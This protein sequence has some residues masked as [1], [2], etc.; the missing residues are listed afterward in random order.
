MVED[1][2]KYKAGPGPVLGQAGVARYEDFLGI[3]HRIE[4]L[5]E[6]MPDWSV[7]RPFWCE[8]HQRGITVAV[9]VV[10]P[11]PVAEA[12]RAVT[13]AFTPALFRQGRDGHR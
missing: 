13:D 3:G 6:D 8:P 4:G 5:F 9:A 10:G 1:R 7:H 2:G 12:A 11:G